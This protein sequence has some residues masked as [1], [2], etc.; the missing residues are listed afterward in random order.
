MRIA[1]SG[2]LGA[3]QG[4]TN[5]NN[6]G[7][8]S[9]PGETDKRP[10]EV[11]A[12]ATERIPAGEAGEGADFAGELLSMEDIYR[13]AGIVGPRRA[14]ATASQS[15]GNAAQR[16]HSGI[17][18]RNEA[19]LGTDGVGCGGSEHRRSFARREG[20]ARGN[21]HLPGR[22]EKIVRGA[23]GSEGGGKP[24]DTAELETV[25]ARYMERVRR[26]LDGVAREKATFGN[27]LTMKQQAQPYCGSRGILCEGAGS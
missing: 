7:M 5:E 14:G 27:W 19:S 16:T 1:R 13:A 25:K 17:V 12:A 10:P 6:N 4:E 21:R 22:A 26:D 9:G 11:T 15:G 24:S 3:K 23:M 2:A 20:A 8:G 18:A